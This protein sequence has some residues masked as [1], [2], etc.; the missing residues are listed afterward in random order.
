MPATRCNGPAVRCSIESSQRLWC[1]VKIMVNARP[2]TRSTRW[3]W[4][5]GI[6]CAGALFDASQTILVMHEED[7]LAV[8]D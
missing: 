2:H 6:W 8:V 1:S 3:I 5:A 7:V 4:I